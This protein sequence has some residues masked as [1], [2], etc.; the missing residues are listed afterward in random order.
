[1][2]GRLLRDAR[3]LRPVRRAHAADLRVRGRRHRRHRLALGDARRRHR[4]RRRADRLGADQRAVLPARRPPRL[5][6]RA[7]RAGGLAGVRAQ[8]SAVGGSMTAVAAPAARVE[9]WTP[10][11]ASFTAG[12]AALLGLLAFAPLVLG[13]NSIDNLIQLYFLVILAMMWNALA[14]YGGL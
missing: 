5:P 2:R 6:R 12:V 4:P 1:A 7:R 11:S 13:D 14:G 9:R 10:V 3:E 8:A